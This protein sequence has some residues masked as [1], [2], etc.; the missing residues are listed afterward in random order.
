M[1]PFKT[2]QHLEGDPLTERDKTEAGSAF[3]NEG[4][5]NSFVEPLLPNDC[6]EMVLVEMGCNAGVF[7]NKAESKGFGK[8]V[9]I[10]SDEASVERGCSWRDRHGKNYQILLERM[11]DCLDN[12]P[13]ADYTILSNSHY[14]FTINDW[15]DYLD[16]LQYKTRYCIII[17]AQKRK[18]N[19]CWARA[20]L[21]GIRDYF[22]T[23]KEV[24]F[25]DTPPLEDDPHPR[26]LWSLCFESPF[27][28]RVPIDSLD[29]GNHVQDKFYAELD[30][31]MD[32]KDTR[33]YKILKPYRKRWSEEKL[34][35][36]IEGRI[37]VYKDL[38]ENG[39]KK[40]ILVGAKNLI[41]DGNHRYSMMKHLGFKSILIRR[42]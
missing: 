21:D 35:T 20:D 16:R 7:L 13:L 41:L 14:Y 39:L 37:K 2:Y 34:H 12:L 1:K 10:D 19:R 15:L 33:Y 5:W 30:A 27:I 32:Y 24:G 8:V 28:E 36:W 38:K 6:S 3:W 26:R 29:C 22:K 11:E 23:W 25:V 31:G 4:K 17:T 18:G 42:T 9:G 40:P